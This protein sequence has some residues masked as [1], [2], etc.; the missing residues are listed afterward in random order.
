MAVPPVPVFVSTVKKFKRPAEL[1][2]THRFSR[3][4]NDT[5]LLLGF[6]LNS[7]SVHIILYSISQKVPDCFG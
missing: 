3:I 7:P 4:L 2:F 6:D 1:L 5:L